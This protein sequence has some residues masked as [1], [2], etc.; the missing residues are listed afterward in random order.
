V[1]ARKVMKTYDP[2]KNQDG[3]WRIAKE[4]IDLLIKHADRDT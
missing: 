4:E 3:S 2:I 1:F